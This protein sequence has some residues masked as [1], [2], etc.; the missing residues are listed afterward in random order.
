LID[1]DE[2][3]EDLQPVLLWDV[4]W[5]GIKKDLLREVKQFAEKL[6]G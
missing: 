5:D 6:G 1:F 3:D 4:T 2:A